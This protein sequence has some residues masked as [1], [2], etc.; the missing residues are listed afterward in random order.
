MS[1]DGSQTNLLETCS[2]AIITVNAI[3]NPKSLIYILPKNQS[4]HHYLVLNRL[5]VNKQVGKWDQNVIRS[6]QP[7]RSYMIRV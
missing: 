2:T 4:I 1:Q 3:G 5:Q 6:V 7:T